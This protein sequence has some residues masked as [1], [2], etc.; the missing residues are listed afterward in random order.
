MKGIYG[1]ILA[2]GLGFVGFV[3]NWIYLADR[4]SQFE[5]VSFLGIKAGKTVNRGETLRD[6]DLVPVPIPRQSVGTLKDFAVLYNAKQSVV[7]QPV[8]R[9]LVGGHILLNEDL[10]TPPR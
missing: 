7:G 8:W 9:T 6:E 10:K 5:T 2:I 4:A 3:L 1:L